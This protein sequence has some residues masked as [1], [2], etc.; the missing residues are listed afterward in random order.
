MRSPILIRH[1][2]NKVLAGEGVSKSIFDN[3]G[4]PPRL[5]K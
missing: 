2:K 4:V 3:I 1:G 5:K